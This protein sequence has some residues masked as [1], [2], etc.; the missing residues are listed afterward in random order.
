MLMANN[1]TLLQIVQAGASLD[2]VDPINSKDL[3]EIVEAAEKSGAKLK[4]STSTPSKT[5]LKI[6]AMNL[7]NVSYINSRSEDQSR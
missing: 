3:L 2:I 7:P 6:L 1:K 5:L 4:I